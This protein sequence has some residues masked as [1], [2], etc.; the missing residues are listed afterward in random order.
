MSEIACGDDDLAGTG[1]SLV[2][3]RRR[4][5]D[6]G[7][8]RLKTALSHLLRISVASAQRVRQLQ[9]FY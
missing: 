5:K 7:K 9:V 4:K 8:A 2:K 1:N 3:S 6:S